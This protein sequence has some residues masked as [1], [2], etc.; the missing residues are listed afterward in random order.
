MPADSCSHPLSD[1]PAHSAAQT[2][3]HSPQLPAAEYSLGECLRDLLD[4]AA[5]ALVVGGR[6]V[7]FIPATPETYDEAEIPTHPALALLYNSEQLLTTRYSRRLLTY[8][9]MT[10]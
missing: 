4:F 3:N 5:R 8:Q 1:L 7:F 6:L 9:K 2:H 10:K